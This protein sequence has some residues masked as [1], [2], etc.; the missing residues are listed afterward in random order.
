MSSAETTSEY[1]RME[2]RKAEPPANPA[3]TTNGMNGTQQLDAAT[4]L[5]S[6][7]TLAK[8]VLRLAVALFT[9]NPMCIAQRLPNH[10]NRGNPLRLARSS[11][12]PATQA[13]SSTCA[14]IDIVAV[15]TD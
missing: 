9:A 6:A 3:A 1:G 7:P 13:R 8:S 4:T 2:D 12:G 15:N 5:A 14:R 10:L 11:V